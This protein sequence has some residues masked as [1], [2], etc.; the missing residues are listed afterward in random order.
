MK[1]EF[2]K[3]YK[4]NIHRDGA[5]KLLAWLEKS[6]FFTAPA[7]TKYHSCHEGGLAEH[8]VN[9]FHR[10]EHNLLNDDFKIH[11]DHN[12]EYPGAESVAICGLLHDVCKTNFYKPDTRNVKNEA[13]VWEKVPYYSVDDKLPYGHGDKSVYIVSG[14]MRLTREEAFAIRFHMGGDSDRNVPTVFRKFPLALM[15]HIADLEA[16][17]IDEREDK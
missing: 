13:G 9:V 1:E 7:S 5:D 12:P 11:F 14:F 2:L 15:L 3:I 10:L 8:S 17:F 4:E 6:D 16:T